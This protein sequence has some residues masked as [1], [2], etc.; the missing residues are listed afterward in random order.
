MNYKC[1]FTLIFGVSKVKKKMEVIPCK[2]GVSDD[3]LRISI[4]HALTR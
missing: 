3:C 1:K 2:N 4:F